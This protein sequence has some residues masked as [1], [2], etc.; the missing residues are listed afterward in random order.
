ML[1]LIA[2]S[3]ITLAALI[4][5]VLLYRCLKPNSREAEKIKAEHAVWWGQQKAPPPY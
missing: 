5:V 4:F 1:N 3:V 2:I